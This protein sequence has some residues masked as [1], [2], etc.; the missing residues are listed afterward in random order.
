MVPPDRI[1]PTLRKGDEWRVATFSPKSQWD[2]GLLFFL[3]KRPSF[4]DLGHFFPEM[5]ITHWALVLG[6]VK[7]GSSRYWSTMWSV[8]DSCG[9]TGYPSPLSP[10]W[11]RPVPCCTQWGSS[12]PVGGSGRKFCPPPPRCRASRHASHWFPPRQC[13]LASWRP[14]AASFFLAGAPTAKLRCFTSSTPHVL[15]S[16]VPLQS[17]NMCDIIGSRVLTLQGS[18]PMVISAPHPLGFPPF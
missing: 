8:L 12:V 1:S 16:P 6:W 9:L 2:P 17:I 14:V 7:P 4:L 13:P 3:P 15:Y 5:I 18:V 10:A 11:A